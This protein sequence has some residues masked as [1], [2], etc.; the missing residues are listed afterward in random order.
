MCEAGSIIF[1]I[2]NF[3]RYIVFIKT[4][5]ILWFMSNEAMQNE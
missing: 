2:D 1:E 4:L 3:W 5:P